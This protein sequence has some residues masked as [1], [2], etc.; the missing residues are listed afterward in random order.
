M[1]RRTPTPSTPQGSVTRYGARVLDNPEHDPYRKK[2]KY[3]EPTRCAGCGAVFDRGRWHWGAAAEHG[4][5][6]TCPACARI[7]DK[8]PAG[9]LTLDGDYVAAH[10]GE[11]V[12]IARHQAELEGAE[13][14]L[15]RIM[16]IA[17]DAARVEITTTDVHL[18]H[19]IGE[20]I[21]RAHDGKLDTHY[22]ADEYSVRVHWHR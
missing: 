21:A 3:E 14:P 9:F 20:A 8:L 4:H 6:A 13:H 17:A 22:G 2:R 19:R 16:D 10:R 5:V 12:A 7:A 18:P 1:S 15:H 11:L